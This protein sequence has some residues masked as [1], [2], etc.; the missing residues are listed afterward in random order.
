MESASEQGHI[1]SFSVSAVN[2]SDTPP[3]RP[4]SGTWEWNGNIG[5]ETS[6]TY[7]CGPY[8]SFEDVGGNK[9]REVGTVIMKMSLYATDIQCG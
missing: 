9:Y 1:I 2:C 7:T 4:E 5:Y 6:I 3:E 8:G